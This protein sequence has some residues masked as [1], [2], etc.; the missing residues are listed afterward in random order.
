MNARIR[1]ATEADAAGMLEIYA[2]V[3]RDTAISFETQPPTPE[4]FRGRLRAALE[5]RLWLVCED[6]GDDGSG[7]NDGGNGT[8]GGVAGY[9]YA[10]QFNF[11]ESYVW[12]VEV[13]VYVHSAY[14]RRGVGRALYESLFRCLALQGF[15]TAIARI[16]LPNPA[17]IALH[18]GMGFRPAG[19]NEGIGHKHGQWHD[20][21]IWQMELR[22][23]P[24]APEPPRPANSLA[25]TPEWEAALQ[26][27]AAHLR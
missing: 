7:A 4:E 3:V 12:A 15:C 5:R 21:G 22:P 20:V 16:T 9:A 6:T 11:R 17:S 2:P 10:A 1:L 27:G 19:L 23:R 8:S 26:S 14:R 24:A 13:S 18:E 25:G